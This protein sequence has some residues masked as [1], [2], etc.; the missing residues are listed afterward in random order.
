MRA[1]LL[2]A[3][4]CLPFETVVGQATSTDDAREFI[5]WLL[6]DDRELKGILFPEVVLAVSGKKV[7]PLSTNLAGDREL[8]ARIGVALDEVMRRMNAADNAIH[9]QERINEV[10]SHF[11]EEIRRVLGTAPDFSCDFPKTATGKVQRSGYPDLRLVDEKSGRVIYLD[12]KLY[13]TGG[14]DS[15]FRSFYFE[16]KKE[17]N[18][19]LDDGH[20]LI[21]GFEHAGR[22]GG[23][24]RFTR[25]DLVDLAKFKV[26]LKAEFQGSNRDLYRPEALVGSGGK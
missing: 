20:H 26:R 21:V 7:I 11:E 1:I 9:G 25:W 19:I 23:S 15:T 2:V 4:L 6:Q 3:M 22:I 10:S 13:E 8:V 18:K 24:W 5:G 17:T 14:R 12:P 16:P